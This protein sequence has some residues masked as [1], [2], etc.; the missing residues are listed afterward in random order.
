MLIAAAG[1]YVLILCP[2]LGPYILEIWV[3]GP[4]RSPVLTDRT[5]DWSLNVRG[6]W[7]LYIIVKQ[8]KKYWIKCMMLC[9]C[10]FGN[11]PQNTPQN[12]TH[13]NMK[14]WKVK[15]I[16]LTHQAFIYFPILERPSLFGVLCGLASD[17]MW[18][19]TW[20]RLVCKL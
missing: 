17:C 9:N 16:F 4:V 2:V 20:V 6:P 19:S 18:L 3:D 14:I 11:S 5:K 12:S 10:N 7:H 1:P 8:L 13:E 15:N